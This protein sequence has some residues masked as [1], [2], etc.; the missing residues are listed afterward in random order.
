MKMDRIRAFPDLRSDVFTKN[1]RKRKKK[2]RTTEAIKMEQTASERRW[3]RV[4][5][6]NV[7]LVYC[8]DWFA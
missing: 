5:F 8:S 2:P 4:W 3:T 6:I 1:P 7:V